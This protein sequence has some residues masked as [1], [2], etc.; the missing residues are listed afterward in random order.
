[1]FESI[2]IDR[3]ISHVSFLHRDDNLAFKQLFQHVNHDIDL[4]MKKSFDVISVE[5][6]SGRGKSRI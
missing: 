5:K 3:F 1:M 6:T 2:P 4:A